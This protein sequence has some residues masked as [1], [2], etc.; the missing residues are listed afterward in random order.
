MS[1]FAACVMG[2][3]ATLS[4]PAPCTFQVESMEWS[5]C[6][7]PPTECPNGWFTGVE[8]CAAAESCPG[9]R[10]QRT[11]IGWAVGVETGK[12]AVSQAC[13]SRHSAIF[14]RCQCSGNLFGFCLSPCRPVGG[15][16]RME[17]CPGS[18][19]T[20]QVCRDPSVER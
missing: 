9:C 20:V 3:S 18:F 16:L 4:V 7:M 15:M 11:A 13:G 8:E 12:R 17:P 2:I 14:A 19:N 10:P 6:V 5:A 1:L